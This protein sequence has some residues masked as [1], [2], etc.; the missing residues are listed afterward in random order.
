MANSFRYNLRICA[1][2]DFSVTGQK[3]MI[4]CIMKVFDVGGSLN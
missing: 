2:P 4:G 3:R 1:S